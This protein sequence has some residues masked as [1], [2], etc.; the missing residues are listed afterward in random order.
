[1]K[2]LIALSLVA[3]AMFINTNSYSML[4][5]VRPLVG[6]RKAFMQLQSFHKSVPQHFDF[7]TA[8]LINNE[9]DD[10]KSDMAIISHQLTEQNKLLKQQIALAEKQL[11]DSQNNCTYLR[12]IIEQNNILF[13]P[14]YIGRGFHKD[15]MERKT[16]WYK[17]IEQLPKE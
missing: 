13:E 3:Y 15:V 11:Q 16:R 17:L 14:T 8:L 7:L 4:A 5:R 6:A 10:R 9:S 1:M 2:K 12:T